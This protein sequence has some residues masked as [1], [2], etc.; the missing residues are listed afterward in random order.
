M[1]VKDVR[2]GSCIMRPNTDS[3]C[4]FVVGISKRDEG[5][6]HYYQ[7]DVIF[8]SAH[9]RYMCKRHEPIFQSYYFDMRLESQ[10]DFC[11]EML[12]PGTVDL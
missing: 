10:K 2:P 4:I 8:V 11:R 7:F 5:G 1:I 12:G 9:D 3:A 6:Y